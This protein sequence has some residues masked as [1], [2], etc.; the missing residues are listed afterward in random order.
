MEY[1][2]IYSLKFRNEFKNI[3]NYFIYELGNKEAAENFK[4]VFINKLNLIQDFPF[5]N[6]I[7]NNRLEKEIRKFKVN[8]YLV[9][10]YVDNN[11]IVLLTIRHARQRQ[12]ININ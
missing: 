5:S 1:K 4:Q 3:L 8:K 10:Y 6:T 7:I 11:E 12:I 9:Y 2:I